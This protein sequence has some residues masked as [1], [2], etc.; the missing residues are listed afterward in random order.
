MSD[1]RTKVGG[2]RGGRSA[3]VPL[4]ALLLLLVNCRSRKKAPDG[5]APCPTVLPDSDGE[6]DCAKAGPTVDVRSVMSSNAASNRRTTRLLDALTGPSCWIQ[7]PTLA[8]L[9]RR[10]TNN[11]AAACSLPAVPLS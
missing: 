10:R 5:A 7:R 8:A 11:A 1:A 9:P 6:F 3:R 2:G 4:R